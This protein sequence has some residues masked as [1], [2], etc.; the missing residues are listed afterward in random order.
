MLNL[1]RPWVEIERNEMQQ[2]SMFG[3]VRVIPN[4]HEIHQYDTIE[5]APWIKAYDTLLY[6]YYPVKTISSY[7]NTFMYM[8]DACIWSRDLIHANITFTPLQ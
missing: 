3:Y 2:S 6:T 5:D 4:S 7:D 8:H 1:T